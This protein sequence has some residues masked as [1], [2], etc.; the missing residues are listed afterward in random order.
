M[1]IIGL[2]ASPRGDRSSTRKLVA[3][4]LEGAASGGASTRIIDMSRLKIGQ[5]KD[6]GDCFK[7]GSCA[8]DDDLLYILQSMMDSDG[9]VMGSP[10]YA[11][12]SVTP[13]METFMERMGEAWH[14]MLLEGRYGCVASVS[15]DGGENLAVARMGEFLMAC[16][17]MVIGGAGAALQRH[18]S[19]EQG[20]EHA[21][22]LG[23]DLV[24]AIHMRRRY[25]EQEGIRAA[26]I[27]EFGPHVTS[28]RDRWA[29]DHEY[30]TKKGWIR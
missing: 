6:C 20:L 15:R 9:I 23:S 24:A 25:E 8:Q 7:S 10:A 21:R 29:H 13:G 30:W 4:A 17:V 16:G 18:G 11:S 2:V 14:C 22:R 1:K 26:F 28:N 5:C 3:A 19:M 12:G 27:K